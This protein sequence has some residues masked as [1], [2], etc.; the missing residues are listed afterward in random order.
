MAN[1]KGESRKF[2]VNILQLLQKIILHFKVMTQTPSIYSV[3][4]LF[5]VQNIQTY[6]VRN[7]M[8]NGSM[9]HSKQLH[10]QR[11]LLTPLIPESSLY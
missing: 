9:H 10:S 3:E 7:P 1:G 8:Q 11:N 2:T 5:S 6:A 4:P